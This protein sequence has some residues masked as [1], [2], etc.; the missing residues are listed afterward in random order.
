MEIEFVTAGAV[1]GEALSAIAAP[2]F[3][4]QTL[5]AAGEALDGASGGALSRA[6]ASSRFAG[7]PDQILD[8]IAPAGLHASRVVLVGAGARG[9]LD[10]LAVERLAAGA[11]HAV[12]S[13]GVST[14]ELRLG[15][16]DDDQAARAA[17]GVRLAAYRFDRYR[18][19]EKPEKKP[20]VAKVRIACS[21][22][23]AATAA[24]EPLA[25]L[26]DAVTFARD[27]V[28]EP[29]NILYPQEFA[30]R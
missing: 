7:E 29:A 30:S 17:L 1:E 3:E 4:N 21:D 15:D 25:A 16:L 13:S 19:K 2:V 23:A 5:G 8:L 20:S 24:F 12:K 26:G 18:T 28:S 22:P 11:Y 14:L 27:L 6:M 10:G 9:K